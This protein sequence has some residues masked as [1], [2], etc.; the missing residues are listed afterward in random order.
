MC[1]TSL[2]VIENGKIWKF[3]YLSKWLMFGFLLEAGR[4]IEIICMSSMVPL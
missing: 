2:K 1:D 4:N 3:L